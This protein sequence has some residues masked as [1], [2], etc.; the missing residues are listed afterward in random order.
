MN[1]QVKLQKKCTKTFQMRVFLLKNKGFLE[2]VPIDDVM[3]V[4]RTRRSGEFVF[5]KIAP[6]FSC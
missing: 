6:F 3:S 2:F 5:K 4:F 1:F